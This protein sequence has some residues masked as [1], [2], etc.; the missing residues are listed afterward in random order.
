MTDPQDMEAARPTEAD[1][2]AAR[3]AAGEI[4]TIFCIATAIAQARMKAERERGGYVSDALSLNAKLA[5]AEIDRDAL[6]AHLVAIMDLARRADTTV[7]SLLDVISATPDASLIAHD[8]ALIER[9][10]AVAHGYVYGD[11]SN[12]SFCIEQDIRALKTNSEGSTT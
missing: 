6:A 1:Y 5:D 10:A 7:H 2:E 4:D 12:N 3:K 11:T 9:C 8:N